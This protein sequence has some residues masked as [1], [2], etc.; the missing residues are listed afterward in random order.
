M[1]NMTTSENYPCPVDGCE[2]RFGSERG[3]G[4]HITEH[5]PPDR[6]PAMPQR[7]ETC[8]AGFQLRLGLEVHSREVHGVELPDE[9]IVTFA[10][11][12]CDRIFETQHGLYQH[13]SKMHD[14]RTQGLRM[15]ANGAVIAHHQARRAKEEAAMT[16]D[17]DQCSRGFNRAG[18]LARHIA[19]D[20]AEPAAVPST[21]APSSEPA[22]PPAPRRERTAKLEVPAPAVP[23]TVEIDREDLAAMLDAISED[24]A[25]KVLGLDVRALSR[26]LSI[27]SLEQAARA[28]RLAV[29]LRK[30]S[31]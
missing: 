26:A 22:D 23:V 1:S 7:C 12:H 11:R 8:G 15:K 10:C 21:E 6:R 5:H 24:L 3:L 2:R 27:A 30:A 4:A 14:D 17:C 18:W 31:A 20:H 13:S 19:K 16:F 29:A 9:E 25:S 28:L